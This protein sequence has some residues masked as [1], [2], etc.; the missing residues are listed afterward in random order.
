MSAWLVLLIS[1]AYV[2]LL[3]MVAWWGDRRAARGTLLRP[4]TWQSIC[5]YALTLAIYNTSWSFYGSVGRASAS[6]WDF[7]PIYIAP[8]IILLLNQPLL[9][10]IYI[11]SKAYHA[12]SITDFMASRYGKSQAIASIVTLAALIS[13]LPY[14]ALQL[15]AVGASFDIIVGATE[16]PGGSASASWVD[17]PFAVALS[18]AVFSI[19]FG[20]RH[21][22]ASEHHRGLMLAVAFE[23]LVKMAA[24]LA[25]SIFIVFGMFDGFGDL[26]GR[27][28]QDPALSKLLYIDPQNATWVSVTLISFFAF[29]CLPQAFHVAMVEN[30]SP[31]H[32][33]SARWLYPLYL[34]GFSIFMVPL[35]IAGLQ[36]FGNTV[37]PDTFMITLPIHA[38]DQ[39]MTMLAFI[40]GF[41]AATGMVIVSVVAL[42]T[43]I[44]NDVVLPAAMRAGY[45]GFVLD[46]DVG[47]RLLLIRRIAVVLVLL[48]AYAVHR[49]VDQSLPLT[50]IGLV[51]FVAIAQLGPAFV[52]GLYWRRA[53]RYGAAFGISAGMAVWLYTL[54][55]PSI[56][57]GTP[58]LADFLGSLEYGPHWFRHAAPFNSGQLDAIS[59][60]TLWSLLANTVVFGVV[61]LLTVD[62][63]IDR[64]QAEAFV[65]CEIE[66]RPVQGRLRA[67]VRLDDLR[68]LIINFLGPRVATAVFDDYVTR[69]PSQPGSPHSALGFADLEAIRFAEQLLSQAIGTASAR[70]VMAAALENSALSRWAARE[71]LDEASEALRINHTLMRGMLESIPQGLC[72]FDRHFR[73]T[74]WNERFLQLL[75]LPHNLIQTGLA[76]QRVI[77]FNLARGELGS[78]GL[79]NF[80]GEIEDGRSGLRWPYVYE[81]RRPDGSVI[82]VVFDRIPEGGYIATFTDVSERVAAAEALLEAKEKLEARVAE[83]TKD[84][85]AAKADAEQANASKTRFLAAASHDLMQPLH[86]ARLFIA[87][88]VNSTRADRGEERELRETRE[89]QLEHALN[90]DA[91]LRSTEQLIESLLDISSLDTG[92]VKPKIDLVPLNSL[93]AQLQREYSLVAQKHGLQFK[94]ICSSAIV[95]TDQGLLRRILQNLLSNAI[96]YTPKGKIVLGCR[97]RG[98]LVRIEIW[99]T[100][101]GIT[102]EHL[103][104]IFEEFKRLDST[105]AGD[106]GLG[107]GLAIVDR[108]CKLL[109]H[110]IE[111]NSRVGAGSTFS[112]L[113]PRI[114]RSERARAGPVPAWPDAVLPRPLTVLCVDD[115]DAVRQGTMALLQEWGHVC[116]TAT[117][118]ESALSAL[119]GQVPDAMLLDYHIGK[120]QT[121]LDVASTLQDYWGCRIPIALVTAN[122]GDAVFEEARTHQCE[123]LLKPLKP[124]GLRRW[125]FSAAHRMV[126]P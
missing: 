18:M 2:A 24:F 103:D 4:G 50:L 66:G 9:L 100:G 84:L 58:F 30:E 62:R 11:I 102:T 109:G 122:G 83:R 80:I 89:R 26:Y 7:L 68:E 108:T 101:T 72:S 43:M 121:G 28:A 99:D 19:V 76:L 32:A 41:S 104:T 120:N 8:T 22:Q 36:T 47:S 6:G 52:G 82:E 70:V 33:R 88:L 48:L 3:F 14:I 53:N 71:M 1:T 5:V 17:T 38:G 44:C 54:L 112:I 65:S 96:R 37:S 126:V 86:A 42:S 49:L 15:K 115:E 20:I 29:L 64:I 114:G 21:V 57:Q 34:A 27:A 31:A 45:R 118:A 10:R 23:S 39:A 85:E 107:L 111:V 55:L 106:R 90:A 51:S 67:P 105:S 125:L 69:R 91:S 40:G 123:V 116:I 59:F 61:S 117:D 110:K 119:K 95:R 98:G 12:S 92:L 63:P 56:A 60:A 13:V 35:A 77:D 75:D 79:S 73:I 78:E 81:R 16:S 87:A 46:G 124:G 25:V 94:V 113:V 93:L 97:S 74:A